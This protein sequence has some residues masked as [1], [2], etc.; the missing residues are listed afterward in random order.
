MLFDIFVGILFICAFAGVAYVLTRVFVKVALFLSNAGNSQGMN[1][2]ENDVDLTSSDSFE[3]TFDSFDLIGTAGSRLHFGL[4]D[5]DE[6]SDPD[7]LHH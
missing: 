4:Y 5:G 6:T 1:S 2:H 3:N 7:D